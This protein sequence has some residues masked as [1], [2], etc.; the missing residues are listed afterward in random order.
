MSKPTWIIVF[1]IFMILF[2]G[3][4]ATGDLADMNID[5]IVAIQ[6]QGMEEMTKDHNSKIKI[7]VNGDTTVINEMD[8]IPDNL[9]FLLGDSLARDSS[10]NVDIV[11]TIMDSAK[12]SEYRIYWTKKLA[13]YSFI[14]SIL[15]ILAGIFMFFQHRF[16]VPAVITVLSLSIAFGLFSFILFNADKDSG[17]LVN[18]AGK[19]EYIL[20]IFIDM[21]MLI[22]FM[23]LDKSYYTETMFSDDQN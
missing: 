12:L 4:G 17:A 6:E 5:K 16:V 18:T 2:G 13:P 8:S 10:N 7:D 21:V 15:F 19:F 3:C 1:A 22:V 23:V 14:I 11:Q 9:K 20:S